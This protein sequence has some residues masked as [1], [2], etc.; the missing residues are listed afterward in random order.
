MISR[1]LWE[2][3]L[4]L[5]AIRCSSN[6]RYNCPTLPKTIRK[7]FPR[8]DDTNFPSLPS[9]PKNISRLEGEGVREEE[10]IYD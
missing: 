8:T 6:G 2:I 10:I 3:N 5:R 9:F 7:T 1:K 4:C